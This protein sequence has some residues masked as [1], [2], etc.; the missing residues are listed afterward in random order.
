MIKD[1]SQIFLL[2]FQQ[3]QSVIYYYIT[4]KHYFKFYESHYA[5]PSVN[6]ISFRCISKCWSITERILFLRKTVMF[7]YREVSFLLHIKNTQKSK[8]QSA[9]CKEIL[10]IKFNSDFQTLMRG[11]WVTYAEKQK[12]VDQWYQRK[13]SLI[14][15]LHDTCLRNK[16]IY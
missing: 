5:R 3:N 16:R 8:V 10:S 13:I 15:C 2:M 4:W 1:K 6:R 7:N 11:H 14:V 9:E 12:T